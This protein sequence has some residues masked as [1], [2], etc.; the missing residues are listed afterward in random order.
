LFIHRFAI[1]LSFWERVVT[2]KR[3]TMRKIR[4]VLRLR[5]EAGLSIRQI[6]ASTKTSVGAIQKLFSRAEA[7]QLAWPLPGE[8]DDTR[9]ASLFYPGADTTPSSRN[10]VPD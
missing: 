7:L 3:I 8:M 10:K 4:D 9:L 5:L 2:T 6:S 1:L